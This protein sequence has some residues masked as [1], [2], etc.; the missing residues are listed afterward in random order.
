MTQRFSPQVFV[1]VTDGRG[2]SE[3]ITD[4]SHR[5]Q[6]FT[7]T[8]SD[9][10][11]DKISL[12]VDNFDL[13]NFDDQLWKHGNLLRVSWG[14]PGNLSPPRECVIDKVSGGTS[15]NVEAHAKSV[16]LDRVVKSRVFENVKR[17]DVARQIA[18]E[19]GYAG[20]FLHIEDTEICMP[21]I[22]QAKMTDA[23]FL[24]R[25]AHQEGFTFF[26][27]FDGFHFHERKLDQRPYRKYVYYTDNRGD[28]LSLSMEHNISARYGRSSVKGRDP[29]TREN[30]EE[31]ADNKTDTD[32]AVL[33]SN[34]ALPATD[35]TR[36]ESEK[37][38]TIPSGSSRV[39]GQNSDGSYIV[40]NPDGT[41]SNQTVNPELLDKKQEAVLAFT[42]E[43]VP[44]TT[45]LEA[46]QVPEAASEE[47]QPHSSANE[48]GM[49][50]ENAKRQA[51]RRHR[52][53]QRG[54]IKLTMSVI[55]DPQQLA[56][57][58][59]T[60]EGIGTR[61]SG[62]YYVQE[63]KHNIGNGYTMSLIC[64]KDSHG[65][66]ERKL[67]RGRSNLPDKATESAEGRKGPSKDDTQT[68]GKLE[69]R[70]QFDPETGAAINTFGRLDPRG[71]TE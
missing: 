5:I 65:E 15:L 64:L 4:Q 30:V 68:Q 34:V 10:K 42:S 43:G 33:S 49:A 3:R 38:S 61:L 13:S 71:K 27:D 14:Y 67:K 51:Q 32:R 69:A 17:S 8:D 24:T 41:V 23:R 2:N 63:V 59:I 50:A 53:A 28:I 35:R 11:A 20:Q 62:K 29:L 60:V 56:K 21:C 45:S 55:G 66:Y 6:S 18:Q 31:V 19:N 26:V 58:V 54:A 39:L 70:L 48:P 12:R 46:L 37:T 1:Q 44:F 25:L 9:K 7:F 47:S 22:T 16:L 40:Q 52:R 36:S 57:T